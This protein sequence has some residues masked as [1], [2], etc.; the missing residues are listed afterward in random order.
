ML[1]VFGLSPVWT[2]QGDE[3]WLY[4]QS[5]GLW[6]CNA[7]W[8]LCGKGLGKSSS[9]LLDI[10][11]V[12]LSCLMLQVTVEWPPHSLPTIPPH[13]TPL[14][15]SQHF[16]WFSSFLTFSLFLCSFS[17]C[18]LLLFSPLS[19]LSLPTCLSLFRLF[20]Y[21]GRVSPVPRVV[22]VK[23]PRV[24]VPLVRRVKSL[25]V[26]LLARNASVLPTSNGNK[27]RCEFHS[28]YISMINPQFESLVLSIQ[29]TFVVIC[30]TES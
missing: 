26:K 19:F 2:L 5:T 21:C 18:P 24:A 25:P 14:F 7:V 30:F 10:N 9:F 15:L 28:V 29:V 16:T 12:T 6:R 8:V 17:V 22:P 4:V 3:G 23:W 27:Q 13:L 11:K 20:E 1:K